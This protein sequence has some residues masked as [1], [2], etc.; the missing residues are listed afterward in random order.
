MNDLN[1]KEAD[2]DEETKKLINGEFNDNMDKFKAVK[3]QAIKKIGEL[4]AK[5]K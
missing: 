3:D 1:V 5:N 2:L 4:G